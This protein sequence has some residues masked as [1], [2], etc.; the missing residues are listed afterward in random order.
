MAG[1]ARRWVL[2]YALSAILLAAYNEWALP[3]FVSDAA[4]NEFWQCPRCRWIE[5]K[6]VGIP[7]PTCE[8]APEEPHSPAETTPLEG[9]GHSQSD[10]PRRFT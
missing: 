10:G 8:G 9:K 6:A 3:S 5:K 4:T 1:T 2:P 7:P